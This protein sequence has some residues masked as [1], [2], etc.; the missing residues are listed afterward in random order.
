MFRRPR[1]LPGCEVSARVQQESGGAEPGVSAAEE[2]IVNPGQS[3]LGQVTE[4][5]RKQGFFGQRMLPLSV[6]P[7]TPS[8]KVTP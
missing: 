7:E 1:V 4:N 5:R 8:D 6:T 3:F 2:Q